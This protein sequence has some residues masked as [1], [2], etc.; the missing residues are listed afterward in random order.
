[1]TPLDYAKQ[2]T[3]DRVE[4]DRVS[5]IIVKAQADKLCEVASLIDEADRVGRIRFP[6]QAAQLCRDQASRQNIGCEC[7]HGSDG[8]VFN[9]CDEAKRLRAA[10][11]EANKGL[12][13]MRWDYSSPEYHAHLEHYMKAVNEN[14][15]VHGM[16]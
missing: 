6:W 4:Q 15:D 8:S 9:L 12:P 13:Q 1:M 14:G 16:E 3:A 7:R 2:I 5:Q 11:E 10:L